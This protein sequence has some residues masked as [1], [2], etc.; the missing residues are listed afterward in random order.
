[1]CK[2]I[3]SL[4][5]RFHDCLAILPRPIIEHPPFLIGRDDAHVN[6]TVILNQFAAADLGSGH[7]LTW[8]VNGLPQRNLG[9][10]SNRLSAGCHH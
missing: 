6:C 5:R 10:F 2:K 9:K 4:R 1:M 8:D 3:V 7:P